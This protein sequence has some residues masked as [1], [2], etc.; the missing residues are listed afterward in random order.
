MARSAQDELDEAFQQTRNTLQALARAAAD[1]WLNP[2][3]FADLFIQSLE[4]AHTRAVVIGRQHAGDDAAEEDD[5]R[6]FAQAIVDDETAFL[7]RFVRD[8]QDGRYDD[9]YGNPDIEAVEHR[10]GLYAS[11]MVGTA[12]EAFVLTSEPGG[13]VWVL[14]AA[15]S[16]AR[17]PELAAG[18]P[19]EVP[20]AV[21]GANQ[22]PC[23]QNC[24]CRLR[25]VD[26]REGFRLPLPEGEERSQR[27]QAVELE[28]E[29]SDLGV[30]ADYGEHVEIAR[31]A[32][33][34]LR[35][36]KERNIPLPDRIQIS[37][38]PFRKYGSKERRRFAAQFGSERRKTLIQVNPNAEYWQDRGAL[39]E[40]NARAQRL[41]GNWSTDNPLAPLLQ[42]LGHLAH[43]L[44]RPR[45]YIRLNDLGADGW[46]ADDLASIRGLVS[47]YAE[48]Q[49]LEFVAEVFVGLVSGQVYDATVMELYRK[50]GGREP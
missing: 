42:E 43:F 46:E 1:G 12:N 25:R 50:L 5:D 47:R 38:R 35:L 21:P 29:A 6:R 33:Q 23:L 27:G 40:V 7:A 15:D 31:L 17:C 22:T 19:Y 28:F 24:R 14:G 13:W 9:R 18:S 4:E 2:E 20:P 39:V 30:N 44:N 48:T 10:A 16:C 41:L 45:D 37:E 11:R 36:A 32:N 34:M 8:L 26:G 49:P 3:R